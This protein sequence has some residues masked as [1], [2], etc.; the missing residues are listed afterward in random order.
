MTN[1][2]PVKPSEE[3]LL[4][5]GLR[6]RVDPVNGIVYSL[7]HC[8]TIG[9][10]GPDGYVLLT[11]KGHVEIKRAHLIWWSHS[12]LWPTQMLDHRDRDRSNDR[13]DNLRVATELINAG[14]RPQTGKYPKGVRHHPANKKNPYAAQITRGGKTRGLGYFKTVEE[15]SARYQ[16]ELDKLC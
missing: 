12:G 6:W 16:Q 13:I 9:Y 5:I 10:V 11:A 1:H 8:Q 14:N 4:W 7:Y 3:T 15:A 2:T